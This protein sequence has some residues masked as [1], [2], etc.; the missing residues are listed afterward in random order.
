MLV[1]AVLWVLSLASIDRI[2][3]QSST[4]NCTAQEID[5]CEYEEALSPFLCIDN[6]VFH[7]LLYICWTGCCPQCEIDGSDY[8]NAYMIDVCTSNGRYVH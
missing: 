5:D 3:A 2:F 7:H 1:N 4:D 6:L 8:P